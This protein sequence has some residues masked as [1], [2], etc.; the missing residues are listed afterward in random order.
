MKKELNLDNVKQDIKIESLDGH[1]NVI[2]TLQYVKEVLKDNNKQETLKHL[3]RLI[4]REKEMYN[5]HHMMKC[6]EEL[7]DDWKDENKN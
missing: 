6:A 5:L 3:N 4:R 2:Q 7:G 1:K